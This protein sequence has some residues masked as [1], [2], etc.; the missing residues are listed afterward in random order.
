MVKNSRNSTTVAFDTLS[1]NNVVCRILNAN[2][3]TAATANVNDVFDQLNGCRFQSFPPASLNLG[4]WTQVPLYLIWNEGGIYDPGSNQLSFPSKGFYHI[5][6]TSFGD[7]GVVTEVHTLRYRLVSNQGPVEGTVAGEEKF[8]CIG[9]TSFGNAD[10]KRMRFDFI[11][12][13]TNP[14]PD[15]VSIQVKSDQDITNYYI[16][17]GVVARIYAYA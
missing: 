16:D 13:C 7:P 3:A 5:S 17:E 10:L 6:F 15:R 4:F 8:H 12:Q 2:D 1:C 11:Y 9:T 14:G